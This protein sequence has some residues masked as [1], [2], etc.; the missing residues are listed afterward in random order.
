MA[1]GPERAGRGYPVTAASGRHRL[2]QAY[3]RRDS[4]SR[5]SSPRASGWAAQSSLGRNSPGPEAT[6][7]WRALEARPSPASPSRPFRSRRDRLGR[8][9]VALRAPSA[10]PWE[11]CR[12]HSV[13]IAAGLGG[14][15]GPHAQSSRRRGA[16][17][18]RASPWFQRAG[19]PGIR[20]REAPP[21][22]SLTRLPAPPGS[23]VP[24]GA[25]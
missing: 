3:R 7:P 10:L 12:R 19:P 2:P 14:P 25:L 1:A 20:A 21:S 15:A 13:R 11:S 6:K 5:T 16:G 18:G 23:S 9:H 8:G 24:E 22:V 4:R 17:S